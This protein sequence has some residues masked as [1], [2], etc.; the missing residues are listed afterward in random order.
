MNNQEAFT[1]SLSEIVE[2][3][4]SCDYKCE[5]G[6]LHLND[7][8]IELCKM[9]QGPLWSWDGWGGVFVQ[10][11]W[12]EANV[13]QFVEDCFRQELLDHTPEDE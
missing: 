10:G 3:L 13:D 7:A 9:T 8:F 11:H 1:M 4:R 12:N 5:A 6:P 2:Q